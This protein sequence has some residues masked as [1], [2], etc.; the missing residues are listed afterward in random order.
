MK[1]NRTSVTKAAR[2]QLRKTHFI[3]PN[4]TIPN[5]K[6]TTRERVIELMKIWSMLY[7]ANE[8]AG[9]IEKRIG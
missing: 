7:A 5:N 8:S 6:D 3:K 2:Y 9:K 1:N 4:M